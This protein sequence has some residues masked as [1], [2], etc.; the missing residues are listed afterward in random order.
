[1]SGNGAK[2]K[3]K[4]KWAQRQENYRFY[5]YKQ[6]AEIQN[7]FTCKRTPIFTNCLPIQSLQSAHL[8]W[9]STRIKELPPVNP[10]HLQ[11]FWA[12]NVIA[13][14]EIVLHLSCQISSW[15]WITSGIHHL[16]S[17]CVVLCRV[18][19]CCVVFRGVVLRCSVLCWWLW[20]VLW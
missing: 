1:M 9:M 14:W 15:L 16:V 6:I 3:K 17:W 18:V 11:K 19:S 10:V 5:R 13:P 8:T 12:D 20:C 2:D 4:T 7:T